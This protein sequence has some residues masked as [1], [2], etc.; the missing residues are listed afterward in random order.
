V[1]V[2]HRLLE[3]AETAVVAALFTAMLLGSTVGI[4]A[5][6]GVTSALIRANQTWLYTGMSPE[7]TVRL[8]DGVRSWVTSRPDDAT[9]AAREAMREFLPDEVAHLSDVRDVMNGARTATGIAA[10]L[11]AVWLV[12]CLVFRRWLQLRNGI[13]A[14][15]LTAVGLVA[16]VGVGALFDFSAAF[17]AFH[18]L[19]F[20]AGTWE[21]PADSLLIRVFPG[22]FWA[23]GG[24]L[25]GVLT[26]SAGLVLFG[27]SRLLPRNDEEAQVVSDEREAYRKAAAAGTAG[28]PSE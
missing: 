27:A 24:A 18:G 13:A 26:A 8:A 25:W 6:P 10:G 2:L 23:A 21:F 22:S 12:A 17:S 19:F 9:R 11:L 5:A 14:G 4:V 16:L 3:I 1:S 28:R 7:A 20:A 15:G